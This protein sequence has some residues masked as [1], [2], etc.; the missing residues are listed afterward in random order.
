[1]LC[2]EIIVNVMLWKSSGFVAVSQWK[3]CSNRCDMSDRKAVFQRSQ[4]F[5]TPFRNGFWGALLRASALCSQMDSAMA[6]K[7]CGKTHAGLFQIRDWLWVENYLNHSS[8]H[9]ALF[10]CSSLL[11]LQSSWEFSS[12]KSW[13]INL[14][15][16]KIKE[17]SENAELYHGDFLYR[18]LKLICKGRSLC[19]CWFSL[20]FSLVFTRMTC[21]FVCL[22]GHSVTLFWCIIRSKGM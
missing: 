8:K 14:L 21:L 3:H 2:K 9:R 20:F 12:R 13:E 10:I 15:L 4:Y 16:F 22:I 11:V 19:L 18:Q 1:M 17:K 7:K 6:K 5:H